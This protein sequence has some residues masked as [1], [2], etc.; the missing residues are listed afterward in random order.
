MIAPMDYVVEAVP[1]GQVRPTPENDDIYGACRLDD[2]MRQLMDSIKEHGLEEPLIVTADGYILSGHRR[3]FACRE[4]GL[5][6][7]PISGTLVLG[8][9]AFMWAISLRS[10]GCW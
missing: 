8:R 6:K 7:V 9:P 2:A 4:L 1:I 10:G 5:K 3:H